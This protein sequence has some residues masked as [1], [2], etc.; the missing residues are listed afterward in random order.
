MVLRTA[1]SGLHYGTANIYRVEQLKYQ[2]EMGLIL[3]TK[4]M[5]WSYLDG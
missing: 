4:L 1:V 5:H 3:R 2:Y